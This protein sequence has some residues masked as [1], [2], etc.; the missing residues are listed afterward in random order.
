MS[1]LPEPSIIFHYGIWSCDS[2]T[3][4]CDISLIP[5]S[6]SKNRI[7]WEEQEIKEKKKEE[8]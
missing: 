5:N 8:K 2:V 1:F 7:D 6:S 4:I 3:V